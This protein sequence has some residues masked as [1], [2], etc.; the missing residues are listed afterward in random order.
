M[1]SLVLSPTRQPRRFRTPD[2]RVVSP[3]ADWECLPPGDPGLTRRVKAAGPSWTVAEKRGRKTFSHGVWAPPANI[4][5]ARGS[6][7]RSGPTRAYARRQEAA[8]RR[9]ETA[10][11]EY[12]EDFRAEVQAFLAFAPA[13][14]DLA[15]AWPRR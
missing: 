3:P 14:A 9:R 8:A 4:D 11:A 10:Q 6:S 2:G 12:V 5:A 1:Q 7:K 15:A 13:Y